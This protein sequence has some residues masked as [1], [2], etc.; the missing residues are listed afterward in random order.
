M[1]KIRVVALALLGTTLAMAKASAEPAV[2]WHEATRLLLVPDAPEG[3]LAARL[4]SDARRCGADAAGVDR[5]RIQ[6]LLAWVYRADPAA[7]RIATAL[8]EDTGIVAGLLPEQDFDGAYRGHLHLVPRLPVHA[9]R[10]HLEDAA[11]ALR[12]FDTFFA[13]VQR[14]S[15]RQVAFRWRPLGL[16]FFESVDRRTPS[17]VATGWTIAHNVRGSLFTSPTRT[18]ETYAHELFH[19]NDQ[20]RG[21]WSRAALGGVY[22]R[23]VARCGT[24][25]ACLGPYTPDDTRVRVKGG[26]Y[27]A[28]MPDN[29]VTEYAAD[30]ARRWYVEHR[31]A[32]AG[33]PPQVPWRCRTPEND[34][35]WRAVAAAFFGGIDLLPPC[36]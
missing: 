31:A 18:R 20:A 3:P 23:I 13:E 7:A 6:G 14:R 30:V 32:L 2:T 34:E 36:R 17:A 27:S 16:R 10:R 26:T 21:D 5:C 4:A 25:V 12:D 24:A 1:S 28:F 9:D 19:L 11:A 33:R 15:G 8:H 22:R 29:G 35:A